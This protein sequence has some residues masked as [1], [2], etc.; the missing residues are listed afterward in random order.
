MNKVF[1]KKT[2]FAPIKEDASRV[3]ISYGYVEVDEENATWLEIYLYKKQISQITLADVKAAI[4]ADIDA[5]T[6]GKILE[7]YEWTILHGDETKAK[8][9]RRIGETI[10]V[11]LS[12][13]NQDNFKEAHRLACLDATKVI[14]IKFKINEDEDK[15]AIYETFKTFDELNQFYLGA[16]AYIKQN[17]LDA[18]WVEKD[19]IDFS[20]YEEFFPVVENN[21]NVSE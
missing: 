1:G 17:C 16:F 9:D 10:K 21:A 4:I 13:E 19:S 5:Q 2:D 20:P 6:D 12:R 3:I 11:W 15:K 8:K 7:G 18:G 14:P